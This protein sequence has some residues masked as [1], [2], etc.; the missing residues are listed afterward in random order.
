MS[1]FSAF[2]RDV[3]AAADSTFDPAV[4]AAVKSLWAWAG[5]DQGDNPTHQ[6]TVTAEADADGFSIEAVVTDRNVY[7]APDPPP[8]PATPDELARAQREDPTPPGFAPPMAGWNPAADPDRRVSGVETRRVST[9]P[10]AADVA[11]QRV[12]VADR[13][14]PVAPATDAA[15]PAADAELAAA[16]H[17]QTVADVQA[18]IDATPAAPDAAS[19]IAVLQADIDAALATWPDSPQLQDAKAQADALAAGDTGASGPAA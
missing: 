7:V 19:H 8:A 5:F 14:T 18:A 10:L 6:Y 3:A 11:E 15:P 17:D 1:E 4:A 13:R 12:G 9:G 2:G 16:E